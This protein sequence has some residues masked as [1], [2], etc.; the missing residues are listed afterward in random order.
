MLFWVVIYLVDVDPA[1]AVRIT[2]GT[3]CI[4][5]WY[6][7]KSHVSMWIFEFVCN[8][9]YW[10]ECYFC[11]NCDWLSLNLESLSSVV[12]VIMWIMLNT[13][14]CEVWWI[15]LMYVCYALHIIIMYFHNNMNSHP[16]VGMMFLCGIAQVPKIAVLLVRISWWS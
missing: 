5:H 6:A 8:M 9:W 12:Y 15:Q 4:L 13:W 2:I 7:F 10:C 14:L 16:S 3:I 11:G 1:G